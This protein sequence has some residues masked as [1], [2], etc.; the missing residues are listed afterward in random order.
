MT[1][2]TP[3]RHE[4]PGHT[5]NSNFEALHSSPATGSHV[6]GIY[7]NERG[8]RGERRMRALPTG[9]R[10]DQEGVGADDAGKDK[11]VSARD[12]QVIAELYGY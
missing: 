12:S 3:D 6:S 1:I 10:S 7:Q 8:P 9:A 4:P 5:P 11:S 2:S